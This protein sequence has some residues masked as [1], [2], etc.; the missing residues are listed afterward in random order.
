[1]NSLQ[2]LPEDVR[3]EFSIDANGQAFATRRAIAR[4]A[5]VDEKSIRNLLQNLGAEQTPHEIFESFTGQKF[6]SDALIPYDLACKILAYYY[7]KGSF[8]EKG[9]TV[10]NFP[11]FALKKTPVKSLE[12]N[13]KFKKQITEAKK[14]ERIIQNRLA[15]TLGGAKEVPTEAGRIDL[16]TSVEIVE[17]KQ[18]NQWKSALGQILVYGEYYPSHKKRIH[19]FGE[20]HSSYLDII[21]RH[22]EKF[23]VTVTIESF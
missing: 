1:M 10:I 13:Q 19:L 12:G 16:L 18:V 15:K 14:P 7:L 5:G 17:I 9:C 23:D 4:L 8:T 3:S 2:H 6:G 21:K 20:C 11:T 22:C